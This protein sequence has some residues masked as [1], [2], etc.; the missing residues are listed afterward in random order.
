LSLNSVKERG[1]HG[2]LR[3]QPTILNR[4]RAQNF[5]PHASAFNYDSPQCE[6][7][8]TD[9]H[10]STTGG[11]LPV[12]PLVIPSQAEGSLTIHRSRQIY[13]LSRDRLK[14]VRI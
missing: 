4:L 9:Y 14:N 10:K 7:P 12:T 6:V 2:A 1:S 8:S 5:L 13:P 11:S 3:S